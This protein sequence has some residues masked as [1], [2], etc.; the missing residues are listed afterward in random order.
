MNEIVK[1]TES[2]KTWSAH[3]RHLCRKYEMEVPF[4]SL[5]KDPPSRSVFKE[6]V[7]TMITAY[8]QSYLQLTCVYFKQSNGIYECL[9]Y[10]LERAPPSFPFL[11]DKKDMVEPKLPHKKKILSRA[12]NSYVA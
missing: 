11:H 7:T 5:C 10:L 2:S 8:Y 4:V 12:N 3:I 6:L 9:N 1:S